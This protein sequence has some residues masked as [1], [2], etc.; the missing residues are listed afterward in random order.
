MCARA[1]YHRSLTTGTP[2]RATIRG[3]AWTGKAS[4]YM[5][6]RTFAI[7]DIHGDQ[8]ALYK[9]LSCLPA[10]DAG[11]TLVFLGDYVDR[12]PH[13]AGVVSY[14]RNLSRHVPARVV[15]LR[16]N[17][18]DAWLRVVDHGWDAFVLP[19]PNGC[20]AAYRSF[21]GAP[22]PLATDHPRAEE[23]LAMQTGSFLPDD[24]IA[25][26]RSL[27]YFYEDDHAIYVHAGLPRGPSGFLHPRDVDPPTVV[28]WCRDEDFFRNYRGKL[29]VFGH[30]RTEYLPE[31]LSGYTPDDPT[32]LW[33][34]ENCVGIDTG[35]GNEGFLT[36]FELPGG[37]VY[38]SRE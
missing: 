6:N 2:R 3:A 14:V 28:L 5:A 35:A 25:W 22:P 8:Q 37:R 1:L 17:H 31:E 20:Y 18:E 15:A 24:V 33:A 27:P 32:D 11:D 29:C 10:L 19:I 4:P 12:G 38:E 13:S 26:F 9:L 36:A 34:G 21:V 30:T 7:G 23:I 16:G